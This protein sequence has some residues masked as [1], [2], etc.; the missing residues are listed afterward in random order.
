MTELELFLTE[1]AYF[2]LAAI[3]GYLDVEVTPLFWY[4]FST[5][6]TLFSKSIIS[7]EMELAS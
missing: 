6:T 5:S 3:E 1:S 7:G 4:L 2:G